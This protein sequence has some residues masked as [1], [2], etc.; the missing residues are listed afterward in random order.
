MKTYTIKIKSKEA[1]GLLFKSR[2]DSPAAGVMDVI[3]EIEKNADKVFTNTRKATRKSF[4]AFPGGY[5]YGNTIF[6]AE[7][8]EWVKEENI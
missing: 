4:D 1:L 6:T 8:I 5:I 3:H 2:Y 7:E